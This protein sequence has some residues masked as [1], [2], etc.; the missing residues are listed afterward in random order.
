MNIILYSD[1]TRDRGWGKV[2]HLNTRKILGI[3]S[4]VSG[5]AVLIIT[6]PSWVWML[7]MGGFLIW[8]GWMLF[9]NNR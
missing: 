7:A 1:S 4:A 6:L 5:L 9:I 8:S 3:A 2:G